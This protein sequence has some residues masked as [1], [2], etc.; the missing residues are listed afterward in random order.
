[1]EW[2]KRLQ[3]PKFYRYFYYRQYVI[4]KKLWD[5]QPAFSAMLGM[6]VTLLFQLFFI[7]L[8]IAA[9]FN[10]DF[11]GFF[12]LNV[13]PLALIFFTLCFIGINY[14]IFYYNGK[15]KVSIKEFENETEKQRLLGQYYLFFYLFI[16]LVVMLRVMGWFIELTSPYAS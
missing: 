8:G 10:F 11:F 13:N 4:S 6:A 2:L 14:L 7:V 15:W 1:M 16:S 3:A 12:I 5:T 9:L